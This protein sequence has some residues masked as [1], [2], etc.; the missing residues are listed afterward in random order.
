MFAGRYELEEKVGSGSF[1]TVYSAIDTRS[2]R[3][4]RV[5]IKILQA[6]LDPS[7]PDF[8]RFQREGVA[9][10]KIQHPKMT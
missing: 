3:Q 2:K 9:M 4:K 6:Q 8:Q 1:G 10:S 7:S 5:A